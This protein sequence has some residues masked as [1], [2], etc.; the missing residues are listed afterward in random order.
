[1]SCYHLCPNFSSFSLS[2]SLPSDFSMFGLS[3]TRWTIF[4][5]FSF[6][7]FPHAARATRTSNLACHTIIF[8]VHDFYL[9][10]TTS[11]L[12]APNPLSPSGSLAEKK[13]ALI[14]NFLLLF[15]LL[16]IFFLLFSLPLWSLRVSSSK[17]L[18]IS[19]NA[20]ALVILSSF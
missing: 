5:G 13:K 8:L 15:L 11:S 1:M 17:M 20:L 3:C 19:I 7:L 12:F 14:W 9:P 4:L 6:T 18:Y 16:V 2:V 10:A